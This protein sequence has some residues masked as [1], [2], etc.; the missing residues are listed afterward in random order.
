[1]NKYDVNV[2]RQP[3]VGVAVLL[4]GAAW[5]FPFFCVPL[6]ATPG[7]GTAESTMADSLFGAVLTLAIFMAALALGLFACRTV[8]GKVAWAAL[9]I[10]P[11]ALAIA[12]D[13]ARNPG[14]RVGSVQAPQAPPGYSQQHAR[15]VEAAGR[16]DLDA[17]R[18]VFDA[19]WTPFDGG[20]GDILL[21][22]ARNHHKEAAELI[23]S[24]GVTMD[25]AFAAAC[26]AQ[27]LAMMQDLAAAG[28]NVREVRGQSTLH[29]AAKAGQ[30]PVIEFLLAHGADANGVE[31]IFKLTPLYAAVEGEG[32]K[33]GDA[34]TVKMLLAH[35][36][37]PEVAIS[38]GMTPIRCANACGRPDL[39]AMLRAAGATR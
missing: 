6:L 20:A 31:G 30:A 25:D 35:G 38:T 1:L 11:G 2:G 17:M 33:G 9:V 3:L 7:R 28:V 29:A 4:L 18:A 5:G 39:E 32:L 22:A 24:R 21:A 23:R 14:P 26:R 12:A 19:G 27:D 34:E 15:L 10:V 8:A 13:L 36:A 37:R 16:G